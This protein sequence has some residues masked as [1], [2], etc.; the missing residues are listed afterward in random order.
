MGFLQIVGSLGCI[1]QCMANKP[2]TAPQCKIKT[3]FMDCHGLTVY[4]TLKVKYYKH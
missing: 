4:V 3:Q 2:F 1:L